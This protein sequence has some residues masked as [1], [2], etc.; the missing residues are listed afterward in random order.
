MIRFAWLFARL[1]W[2]LAVNGIK[3]AF[4]R[5]TTEALSRISAL[6]VLGLL[7]ILFLGGAT[8]IGLL[9]FAGGR[10][11]GAGG[12]DGRVLLLGRL[13]LL[14]LMGLLVL[15]SLFGATT[16]SI[17]THNRLRLLPISRH[18]LHTIEVLAS[19]ADPWVALVF[20]GL[21]LFPVGLASAGRMGAAGLA[22]AAG[23][24]MM[25]LL[26]SL[27]CLLSL[28]LT[29][30]LRSRR[31][32][33]MFTLVIV[34]SISLLA[35]LPLVVS[36]QIR[37]A[38]PDRRSDLP[39][40]AEQLD[41]SL[42][43]WS[44]ALPSE[45]YG[46][47]IARG[48]SG[49][50]V[51]AWLGVGALFLEAGLLYGLSSAVY[52]KLIGS[53]E[54]GGARRQIR[55]ESAGLPRV[56][57]FRAAT[58][59]VAVAQVRTALRSVRGRVI[60]VL[61]GPLLAA[62]ALVSRRV[63]D[64]FPGGGL[65]GS[66]GH[67][68]FGAALFFCLY[69]MQAFTMNQFGTDRA[70]LSRQFLS[71]TSDLDLVYGKALGSGMIFAVG[72]LLCLACSLI[73]APGGSPL[74]WL[75]VLLGGAATYLLLTPLAVLASAAF[76]VAADLTKTGSGGNPHSAAFLVG[77]LAMALLATPP[78]LII[79]IAG[80]GLQRPGLALQLMAL[81]IVLAAGV[82]IPLLRLAA[83]S[84]GPRRENLALVAQGR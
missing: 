1:R 34:L 48:L 32:A 28:L 38:Q 20:P 13:L 19:L 41:R 24:A 63:P 60:V 61:P 54:S 43:A 79:G 18:R 12:D 5:D 21:L 15:V 10:T 45:L 4:R 11:V 46:R 25:V 80:H 36:D 9:G 51:A 65:L 72:A 67:V 16:G 22:L 40:S 56:W 35:M 55:A 64:A 8:V 81:W 84:V 6:I 50:D 44:R 39:S 59:A 52:G 53:A 2:R 23:L 33:E 47:S 73:V 82:A 3:G 42:P 49:R 17:A 75:A 62:M 37:D 68:V 30:F 58:S 14:V 57:G 76:P 29:W 26:G 31:R 70:G 77:T 78:G 69:A 71:P 66:Q 83:R 27:A 7:L 74:A